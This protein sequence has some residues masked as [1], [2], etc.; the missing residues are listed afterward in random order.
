MKKL[1]K[2]LR[3]LAKIISVLLVIVAILILWFF[4]KF[5]F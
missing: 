2:A 5:F 1:W 4:S 3:L